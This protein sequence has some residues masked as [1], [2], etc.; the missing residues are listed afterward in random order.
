MLAAD[1]SGPSA[2]TRP[3]VEVEAEADR[4]ALLAAL[5]ALPV[6]QRDVVACRY[7]LDL[8]EA[9]TAAVLHLAPG[10]VKS[11]LSRGLDRLRVE[12][13]HD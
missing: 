11:H 10:T 4:G 1:R 2:P 8:S 12:L 9:E 6:R 13:G 7:L 5:R 3:D